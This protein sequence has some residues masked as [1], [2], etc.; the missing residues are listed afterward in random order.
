MTGRALS[1]ALATAS[2]KT[3]VNPIWFL[4][5]GFSS[6][7][8]LTSGPTKTW[9]SLSWTESLMD[10]KGIKW[11]GSIG[12]SVTI[13]LADP[14][15]AYATLCVSQKLTNRAVQL[16]LT[17]GSANAVG[18][19]VA[20]PM[21]VGDNW[22]IPREFSVQIKATIATNKQLPAT[23]WVALLPQSLSMVDGADLSWGNGTILIA[24]RTVV[25]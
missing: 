22:A 17:D 24:P 25:N 13:D 2:V 18:D 10:I 3:I 23:Q 8:R 12:Q 7:L 19:P 1:S 20:M 6:P 16:W 21:L 4:Q 5:I 14:T 15:L 9:N 11:D